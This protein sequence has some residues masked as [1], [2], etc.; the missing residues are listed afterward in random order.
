M[1]QLF[2]LLLSMRGYISTLLVF[3]MLIQ[4]FSTTIIFISFKA[5]QD[6]IAK[7]L[8]ENRGKPEKHCCG[9]CQLKKRLKEEQQSQN[10]GLP[11]SLKIINEV[12]LMCNELGN[13]N[14]NCFYNNKLVYPD[15][16]ESFSSPTLSE[17]FR[18]PLS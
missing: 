18:P 14:L 9:K 7:N 3:V 6:F 16:S 13:Q 12:V 5:N 15:L 4:T 8:C 10:S 1:I 2:S 11:S 17:I